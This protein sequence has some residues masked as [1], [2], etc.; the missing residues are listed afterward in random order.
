M[1]NV[2]QLKIGNITYDVNDIRISTGSGAPSGGSNGDIYFRKDSAV[3]NT[4]GWNVLY[5]ADGTCEC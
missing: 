3:T 2:N 1:A 5:H 4:N